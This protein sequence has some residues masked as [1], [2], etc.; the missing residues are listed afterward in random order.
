M[1]GKIKEGFFSG[2]KKG[3][4]KGMYKGKDRSDQN[5]KV[6]PDC[7]KPANKCTC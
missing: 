3:M 2:M 4:K 7:G 1:A 6:C 5:E